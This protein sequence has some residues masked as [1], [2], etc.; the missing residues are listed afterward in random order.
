MTTHH[1]LNI[2][3]YENKSLEEQAQALD[4][5][6]NASSSKSN[7]INALS[8]EKTRQIELVEIYL[9]TIKL[10]NLGVR[11]YDVDDVMFNVPFAQYIG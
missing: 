8:K 7:Q 5:L 1:K 2:T 4:A 3:T 9:V 11:E 10:F 6:Y